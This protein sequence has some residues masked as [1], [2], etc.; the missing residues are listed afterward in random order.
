MSDPRFWLQV[1]GI[2]ITLTGS[3]VTVIV[4]IAKLWIQPLTIRIQG[5]ET[6]ASAM[7]AAEN[8]RT[9]VLSRIETWLADLR[10]A[11]EDSMAEQSR[12][13]D[14]SILHGE[15][16]SSQGDSIRAAHTRLD[17]MGAKHSACDDGGMSER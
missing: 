2:V 3:A 13:R 12:L 9:K 4:T 10:P 6:I 1:I 14:T 7:I 15:R 8:E 17:R 5:V 11:F 16:I